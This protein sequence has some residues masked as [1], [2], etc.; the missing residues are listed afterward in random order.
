MKKDK[1]ERTLFY[2]K[3]NLTSGAKSLI[4]V[5]GA[6]YVFK[7][8]QHTSLADAYRYHLS[9]WDEVMNFM[10]GRFLHSIP[11]SLGFFLLA[12]LSLYIVVGVL[13]RRILGKRFWLNYA[14]TGSVGFLLI[15][16]A[17]PIEA[18][19]TPHF[20]AWLDSYPILASFLAIFTNALYIYI[21]L[22]HLDGL[23][24]LR[25]GIKQFLSG[26]MSFGE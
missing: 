7:A 14:T 26:E 1:F 19:V 17:G 5:V 6:A 20:L 11:E 21:F 9:G 18:Y 4:P 24:R 3:S 23:S 15:L 8:S 22:F 12:S 2:W 10:G 13:S 16:V 25:R